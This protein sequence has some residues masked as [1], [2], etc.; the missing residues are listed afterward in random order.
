M[1]R[2]L[3]VNESGVSGPAFTHV[4]LD[5]EEDEPDMTTR[6]AA[7]LLLLVLLVTEA[8]LSP[9]KKAEAGAGP[10]KAREERRRRGKEHRRVLLVVGL[11]REGTAAAGSRF[12]GDVGMVLAVLWVG[13]GKGR[14]VRWCARSEEIAGGRGARRPTTSEAAKQPRSRSRRHT[15]Q[16]TTTCLVGKPFYAKALTPLHSTQQYSY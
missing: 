6:R 4:P 16:N 12:V 2:I 15:K 10:R 5:E 13:L 1:D 14:G 9:P 7:K 3:E 8:G 11:V